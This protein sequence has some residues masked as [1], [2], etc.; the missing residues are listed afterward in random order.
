VTEWL[1]GYTIAEFL[2]RRVEVRVSTIVGTAMAVVTMV[3]VVLMYAGVPA[4]RDGVLGGPRLPAGPASSSAGDPGAA[5]A[6]D[7]PGAGVGGTGVQPAEELP[8][9]GLP[10]RVRFAGPGRGDL[11]SRLPPPEERGSQDPDLRNVREAGEA[12]A[13]DAGPGA[14]EEPVIGAA[15]PPS[16]FYL[17]QVRAREDGEGVDALREYFRGL[18]FTDFRVESSGVSG[19]GR[20]RYVVYLGPYYDEDEADEVREEVKSATRKHPFRYGREA[21][22]DSLVVTRRVE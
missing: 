2:N 5:G 3:L 12:Q 10:P 6:F 21:F 9:V 16:V 15:A 7:A 8:A 11:E 1:L 19:R 17:V 14:G 20:G 13:G 22:Q 4:R 18:G